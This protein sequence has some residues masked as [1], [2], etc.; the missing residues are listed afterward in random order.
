MAL[1]IFLKVSSNSQFVVMR[2]V[3]TTLPFYQVVFGG[4]K[5]RE[6]RQTQ[7]Q[8]VRQTER[9]LTSKTVGPPSRYS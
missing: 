2:L 9:V 1:D 7:G 3:V 5:E 4:E 8:T 6:D